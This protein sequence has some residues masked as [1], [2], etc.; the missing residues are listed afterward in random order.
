MGKCVVLWTSPERAIIAS[1]TDGQVEIRR[2]DSSAGGGVKGKGPQ[3]SGGHYGN[4]I[5][6]IHDAQAVFIFGP[7]QAKM[8]LKREIQEVETLSNNVVGTEVADTMT[9][10]ELVARAREIW[11]SRAI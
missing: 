8:D 5:R 10:D 11:G 9:E 3:H 6:A 1:M 4:V 7:A 2:V